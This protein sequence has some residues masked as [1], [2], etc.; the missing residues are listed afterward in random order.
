MAIL[1]WCYNDVRP[2]KTNH[3]GLN[4]KKCSSL[5]RK[6]NK[7]KNLYREHVVAAVIKFMHT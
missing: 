7:K 4:I 1:P 2:S 3:M 5:D 6:K